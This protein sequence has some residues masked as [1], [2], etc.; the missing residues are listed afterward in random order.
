[1]NFMEES[2][3]SG[4]ITEHE[5]EKMKLELEYKFAYENPSRTVRSRPTLSSW[6][7]LP[8]MKKNRDLSPRCRV[9]TDHRIRLWFRVISN[10][11][12]LPSS[13]WIVNRIGLDSVLSSFFLPSPLQLRLFPAPL[14]SFVVQELPFLEPLLRKA[15]ILAGRRGE[16][17]I[18]GHVLSGTPAP[19]GTPAP[20]AGPRSGERQRAAPYWFVRQRNTRQSGGLHG[21]VADLALALIAGGEALGAFLP[22][23]F[24]ARHRVWR[25]WRASHCQ[26]ALL[27]CLPG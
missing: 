10:A 24:H 26:G 5:Q 9:G 12:I 16:V 20:A 21:A 13:L 23:P 8:R 3:G 25:A 22:K 18:C 7:P 4:G 6:G 2:R 19:T 1:M 11:F 15:A 27:G 17:V 14:R